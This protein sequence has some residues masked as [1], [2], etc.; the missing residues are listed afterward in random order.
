MG[1]SLCLI[2]AKGCSTRL[3]RKNML[4]INGHP[5]IAHSIRKA[6]KSALFDVVCVSTEDAEIAETARRYGAEVP[7]IRPDELSRDPATIIDVVRHA[8]GYFSEE[9]MGFDDIVVLLPTAPFVTVDDLRRA[10]EKFVES[11]AESLLSVT[12]TESP[13]FNAWLVDGEADSQRLVPCFPDSPYKFVK[14]TECPQTYRSN[15]A[16]LILSGAQLAAKK[17]Y[18]SMS[19]IPYIMPP[20]RSIDIDTQFEFSLAQQLIASGLVE[21]QMEIFL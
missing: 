11:G 10:K 20:E 12:M 2:P 16:V 7:F 8:V 17:D 1:G 18:R 15:G 3:P 5:L 4:P 13:P 14:S 6:I 19:A 9:E 21:Q